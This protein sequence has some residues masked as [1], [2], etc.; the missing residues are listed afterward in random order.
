MIV[1]VFVN[2]EKVRNCKIAIMLF[3]KC[4]IIVKDASVRSMKAICNK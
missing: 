4:E 1:A 3:G 2:L